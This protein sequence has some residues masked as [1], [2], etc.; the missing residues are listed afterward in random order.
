MKKNWL[1]CCLV[2][3]MLLLIMGCSVN[4][5]SGNAKAQAPQRHLKSLYLEDFETDSDDK[6][7]WGPYCAR[8]L[9]EKLAFAPD[10]ILYIPYYPMVAFEKYIIPENLQDKNH[11]AIDKTQ[12]LARIYGTDNILQ[13]KIVKK[14]KMLSFVGKITSLSS[15]KTIKDIN[16][17]GNLSNPSA[18]FNQL[19]NEVLTTL[20]VPLSSEQKAYLA[21]NN[22]GNEKAF[23]LGIE[24]YSTPDGSN[25]KAMERYALAM[26]ADPEFLFV[27]NGHAYRH[28]LVDYEAGLAELNQLM[29]DYPQYYSPYLYCLNSIEENPDMA[30]W[31]IQVATKLLMKNPENMAAL[32]EL[33]VAR[34]NQNQFDEADKNATRMLELYPDCWQA[35]LI[36]G[37]SYH[38][39]A[40]AARDGRYYSEM[41]KDEKKVFAEYL[42][43]AMDEM[44]LTAE[45]NPY[46]PNALGNLMGE[47][48][49]N[50]C[51]QRDI[52]K[53][54]TKATTLNP[55]YY[56]VW[57]RMQWLYS[58]GYMNEPEKQQQLL[59][60]GVRLNPENISFLLGYLDMFEW[61]Q[62]NH[63]G[64]PDI[65]LF[66]HDT[67]TLEL[68]WS[69]LQQYSKKY[70][71]DY[72]SL[73]KAAHAYLEK[74]D[75]D[76]AW[77]FYTLVPDDAYAIQKNIHEFFLRK[78][79]TAKSL[80]KYPEAIQYADKCL[81]A[82]P[83]SVCAANALVVKGIIAIVNKDIPGGFKYLEEALQKDSKSITPR[84]EFAYYSG[85]YDY[86]IDKG[87][88]CIQSVLKEK[89]DNARAYAILARLYYSKKDKTN[90]L[91]NV[92]EALYR[93]S[94]DP[95][96]PALKTKIQT[97]K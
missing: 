57:D 40:M 59:A 38:A 49:D 67:Q 95:W 69:D 60:E 76:K 53:T 66:S 23:Q 80:H 79:Q 54:F 82:K 61:Y 96:F 24:A 85:Q 36:A 74:G 37:F 11:K 88:E 3:W 55:H 68:I 21:R 89:P 5:W 94:H 93:D 30:Y 72:G 51:N 50:G 64:S 19:A 58:P 35:H 62:Y 81:Q 7:S 32:Y 28:T 20:Q 41:N 12:Y 34:C 90:A 45:M 65:K 70:P 6:L 29:K 27:K 73:S 78:S 48:L 31:S 86:K 15:N 83:C 43:K 2:G 84:T 16:L 1:Y 52:E 63:P 77:Y 22:T 14:G 47:L 18:F 17:S 39:R 71:E 97:L 8:I 56:F 92:D 87:M 4:R 13:G 75:L 46:S 91:K 33:S 9:N 42:D 10:E 25:P 44:K 26:K